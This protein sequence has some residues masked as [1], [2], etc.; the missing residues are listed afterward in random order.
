VAVLLGWWLAGERVSS[1]V[2]IA[3]GMVVVAV[4]LVD[5]GLARLT[6]SS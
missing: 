6:T 5:R 4:F 1:N 2:L 3:A